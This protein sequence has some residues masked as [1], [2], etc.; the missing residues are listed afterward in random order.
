M[1]EQ[2][3]VITAHAVVRYLERICGADLDV[4]RGVLIN[5]GRD[6]EDDRAVIDVAR[7][8]LGID[9]QAAEDAM[10]TE[11]V[12]RAVRLGATSVR[13]GKARLVIRD[14]RVVTVERV[15]WV[16]GRR[17][18]ELDRQ[19]VQTA[20][21]PRRGAGQRIKDFMEAWA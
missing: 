7:T 8:Y 1:S 13:I 11:A 6:P 20:P 5:Q 16:M 19:R 4:A 21:Q 2:R 15:E 3:A 14:G 9:V 18:G 12:A 10:Q 17:R